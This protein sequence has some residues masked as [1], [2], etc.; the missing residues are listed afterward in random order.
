MM[1]KNKGV[2]QPE[3]LMKS[4]PQTI[5]AGVSRQN[6][7][8]IAFV[9]LFVGFILGATVAILKTSRD[10]K[11]VASTGNSQ[12]ESPVNREDDIR[13]AKSILEKDPRDLQTLITLGDACFDTDRYQEAIDAYSKALAIDPKNPDVRTDMGIMYRKLGQ[14][15][16]ALEAFRQAAKDQPMHANSRFNIGVVL[17]YD[18]K[19]YP[20]AIQAWEEFIKLEKLLDPGDERPVMVRQEIESMK[21]SLVN[22]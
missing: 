15:D 10:S 5:H 13:I 22:R 20:G 4:K 2:S 11:V 19:D 21:K 9:C 1:K 14:F 17:K 7:I 3:I 18:K 12:E 6:V 8:L 16:K